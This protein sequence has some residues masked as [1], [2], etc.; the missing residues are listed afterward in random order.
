MLQ[1]DG[2]GHFSSSIEPHDYHLFL[3]VGLST[4]LSYGWI[5]WPAAGLAC[6]S[7]VQMDIREVFKAESHHP[8]LPWLFPRQ[9]QKDGKR[10]FHSEISQGCVVCLYKT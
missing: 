7:F 9:H 2:P 5:L 3:V 4:L 8:G 6:D 1:P 10:L